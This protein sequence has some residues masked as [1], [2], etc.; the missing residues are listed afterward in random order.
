MKTV[1]LTPAHQGVSTY[2][3]VHGWSVLQEWLLTQHSV[4]YPN[5]ITNHR[6]CSYHLFTQQLQDVNSQS[7]N[8]IWKYRE[9]LFAYRKGFWFSRL[10]HETRTRRLHLKEDIYDTKYLME[11]KQFVLFYSV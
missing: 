11:Q 2:L 9:Q 7:S 8:N 1:T 4:I 10:R 5:P 6:L 3:V